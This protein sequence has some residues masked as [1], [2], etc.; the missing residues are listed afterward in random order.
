M[1]IL[2]LQFQY[3]HESCSPHHVECF[4]EIKKH[5]KSMAAISEVSIYLI[6]QPYD[7]SIVL[8]LFRKPVC[9]LVKTEF[10][11]RYHTSL[12]ATK[13]S[14]TSQSVEVSAMGLYTS[15]S[16]ADLYHL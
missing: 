3:Y 14:I 7:L 4:L 13:R 9:I 5:A 16:R 6:L 15:L 10:F 12:L 1:A 2:A 8:R 11:S